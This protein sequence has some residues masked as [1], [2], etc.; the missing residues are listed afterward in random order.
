MSTTNTEIYKTTFKNLAEVQANVGKEV[1]VSPWYMISQE[2]INTFAEVTNDHQWIHVDV[3]RSQKESPFKTTIAHGFLVL[4]FASSMSYECMSVESVTMGVNYGFDKI[5]FIHP[6]PAGAQIRGRLRLKDFEA[7]K[8]GARYVSELIIEIKGVEKPAIV[9][10]WIGQAY[11]APGNQSVKPVEKPVVEVVDTSDKPTAYYEQHGKVGVVVLNRPKSY[12]AITPEFLSDFSAALAEAKMDDQT[13]AV[14]VHGGTA[15][16]FCAGADLAAGNLQHPR[17]VRDHLNKD[18]GDVV[19]RLTEMDKPV[20]A[21][22]HGSAAGAGLG[23]A[24]GADFRVMDEKANMRYAFINIG[25]APDAGSSWFLTRTVGYSK[26]LEIVTEGEKIPAAECLRLNL[27]N[28]VV[29]AGE[30]L[31]TAMEWATRLA[32]RPTL[33]FALSKKDIK[34]AMNHSLLDTIAYEAEQQVH[35][36]S[37]EDFAEGGAAFLERRKPNF[38]GK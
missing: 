14:V 11:E 31:K 35:G 10:D 37:S 32:D 13:R 33:G 24:L 26:A 3:E 23:F 1:G 16:G 34:Y 18:Y 22:I 4:S 20:I 25:L 30:A 28:K 36:L 27:T 6:V 17:K 5:R 21:A 29:P 38:K 9:A 12:N 7:K 2:Q 8:V 15:K 19:R